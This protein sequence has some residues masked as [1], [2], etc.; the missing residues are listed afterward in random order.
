MGDIEDMEFI[1][2]QSDS[3]IRRGL[4]PLVNF[5]ISNFK[6]KPYEVPGAISSTHNQPRFGHTNNI[7]ALIG[8]DGD[9]T[10]DYILGVIIGAMIILIVAMVWFFAIVCLKIS[11]QERVGFLAGRLIRPNSA[12]GETE[13]KGGVE[14]TMEGEVDEAIPV[15]N[16][17]SNAADDVN[18]GEKM[19]MRRVWAVRGVFVLCGILVMVAGGLFYGK[20]VAAFNE[21]INEVREGIELVQVAANK[22]IILADSVLKAG[23]DME[24]GIQESPEEEGVDQSEIICGLGTDVSDQIKI[25]YDEL[26]V[27]VVQLKKM[28]NDSLGGLSEDLRSLISLTDNITKTLDKADGL[29]N[30]LVAISIFIYVIIVTMLVGVFF[31]CKG[32]SNCVTK[33]IQYSIIWPLFV[34][35][36]VLSWILATLFLI[37][38]LSGADFCVS[39][40]Q[41][42]QAFLNANADKFDGILY[43]F[44]IYYVSGCRIEPPGAQDIIQI[45]T[46][47][48]L[49]MTNAHSL[50]E[51]LGTQTIAT[52]EAVCGFSNRQAM[53]L[54]NIVVLGHDTIHVLNSAMVGLRDVLSCETFNPIY[55]TFV[56]KAFCAQGVSGLT[57][58]FSTTIVMA[59]FSM[60][61]I[62]FR[63]ALY[64][65]KEPSVKA[66]PESGDAVEVVKYNESASE[67]GEEIREVKEVV[68]Y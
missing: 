67:S 68:I 26:S 2:D 55:T 21:S 37:L 63:A 52:I 36:L 39:P 9:E 61:M 23:G 43:G 53:A 28:L 48:Q 1:T 35:M 10:T 12:G 42:V 64:P 13:E 27:N 11:G 6:P 44:V 57:Y 25:A 19:F 46:Q 33:C 32:V 60:V 5:T 54:Q 30:T 34:F 50:F 56:H 24:E 62:M 40:D 18:H 38:S 41:H 45:A 47:V 29:L 15:D 65:I 49:V 22:G 59:I 58:I 14:V 16:V 51:S 17:N 66:L 8:G 3:A 7:D 20:G 31:A 4:T